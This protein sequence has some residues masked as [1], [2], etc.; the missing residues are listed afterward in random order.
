MPAHLCG[1]VDGLC[2]VEAHVEAA[3]V[4]R[5]VEHDELARLLLGLRGQMH[6]RGDGGLVRAEGE[7]PGVPYQQTPAIWS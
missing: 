2:A 7:R 3:M 5:R 1:E 6:A 4:G